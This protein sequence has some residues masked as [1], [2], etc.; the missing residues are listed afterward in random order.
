MTLH[1]VIMVVK[2]YFSSQEE[3]T[4]TIDMTND[5]HSD[6]QPRIDD[7]FIIS[8]EEQRYQRAAS[9]DKL[10]DYCVEEFGKPLFIL[11][12]FMFIQEPCVLLVGKVFCLLLRS[13]HSCSIVV[14]IV[15]LCSKRGLIWKGSLCLLACS[16]IV[17]GRVYKFIIHIRDVTNKNTFLLIALSRYRVAIILFPSVE[18]KN[19][20]IIHMFIATRQSFTYANA[21]SRGG[22]EQWKQEEDYNLYWV[23]YFGNLPCASF[24]NNSRECRKF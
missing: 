3:S 22:V 6:K 7:D 17:H 13:M 4:E 24:T 21:R 2:F 11:I 16:I 20:D 15:L 8:D 19:W 9:L 14:V 23:L 18:Q 10:V 1:S 12:F 5:V